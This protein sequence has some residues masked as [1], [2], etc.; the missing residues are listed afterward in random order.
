[1]IMDPRV[2]E[3][4]DNLKEW[5]IFSVLTSDSPRVGIWRLYRSEEHVTTFSHPPC[6]HRRPPSSTNHRCI[7]HCS[8]WWPTR[9]DPILVHRCCKCAPFDFPFRWVIKLCQQKNKI[10]MW[11]LL[12]TRTLPSRRWYIPSISDMITSDSFLVPCCVLVNLIRHLQ[13]PLGLTSTK[14]RSVHLWSS[15]TVEWRLIIGLEGLLLMLKRPSLSNRLFGTE[16]WWNIVTTM[17]E[18]MLQSLCS[19]RPIAGIPRA[20]ALNK[21]NR[22]CTSIRHQVWKV[23]TRKLED[24]K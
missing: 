23:Y 18:R 17:E 6:L 3:D 5:V 22:L 21:V 13:L 12:L 2:V 4:D 20:E 10:L 11:F 19:R 15:I 8:L 16:R 24:N 14:W 1:M 9:K 7:C